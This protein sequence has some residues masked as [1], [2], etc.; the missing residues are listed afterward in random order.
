MSSKGAQRTEN[1]VDTARF[2]IIP[3]RKKASSRLAIFLFPSIG[4]PHFSALWSTECSIP[5]EI[6]VE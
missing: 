4:N 5:F 2:V 6:L 1:N 3:K